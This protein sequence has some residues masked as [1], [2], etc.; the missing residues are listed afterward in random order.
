MRLLFLSAVGDMV[1]GAEKSL[2]LLGREIRKHAD[3]AITL[4]A[5]SP[6]SLCTAFEAEGARVHHVE[7]GTSLQARRSALLGGP[8]QGYARVKDTW[9][10]AQAVARI[11]ERERVALIHTNGLKA[12]VIGGLAGLLSSTPVVWH[13]RDIVD[14]KSAWLVCNL[15]GSALAQHVI[16]VSQAVGRSLPLVADHS[17]SVVYNMTEALLQPVEPVPPR[18]QGPLTTIGVFGRLTPWKG[19]AEAVAVI[20]EVRRAVP[21]VRLLVVGSADPFDGPAYENELTSTVRR[22]GLGGC[23]EFTGWRDD[24]LAVMAGCDIVVHT[25]LEPDPCPR[26]VVDALALGKPVI[27]YKSGGVPELVRDGATGLLVEVGDRSGLATALTKVALDSSLAR[28]LG[29]AARAWASHHFT[30]AKHL[31]GVLE[32]YRRAGLDLS[33]A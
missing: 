17:K 33:R 11:A 8:Q 27:A 6:G 31:A 10:A 14:D 25:P 1:G 3:I 32:A 13:V 9:G 2:L 29:V 7:F 20:P 26:T 4:V 24:A 21:D 18:S 5:P 28:D 16:C 22:E 23:V 12:H 15:G 19:Q 30:P